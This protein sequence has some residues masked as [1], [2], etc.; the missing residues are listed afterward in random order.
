MG[1]ILVLSC[2]LVT[3]NF[4]LRPDGGANGYERENNHKKTI[5]YNPKNYNQFYFIQWMNQFDQRNNQGGD[6]ENKQS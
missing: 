3:H 5:N 2:D 1:H 6:K 4:F